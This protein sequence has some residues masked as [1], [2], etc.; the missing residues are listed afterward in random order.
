MLSFRRLDEVK[1]DRS[2]RL[3]ERDP[4]WFG[5]IDKRAISDSVLASNEA[6]SPKEEAAWIGGL[7]VESLIAA[8]GIEPVTRGL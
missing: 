1:S 2:A 4:V 3:G 5:P 6:L 7:M 8:T